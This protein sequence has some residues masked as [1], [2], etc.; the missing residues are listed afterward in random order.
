MPAR[1]QP[2][3]TV[4]ATSTMLIDLSEDLY[5]RTPTPPATVHAVIS[6]PV[7]AEMITVSV[8]IQP[9]PKAA[10]VAPI[11]TD[12]GNGAR[13]SYLMVD[14]AD[15]TWQELRDYVVKQ[16]SDRNIRYAAI[17]AERLA[18]IFKGFHA[19]WGDQ[20][21]AIARYAFEICEGYWKSA[22]ITP[23]R[24]SKNSDPY[25]ASLIA[26]RLLAA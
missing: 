19:R 16:L 14:T 9:E 26:P 12:Y 21:A 1:A 15:W 13:A 6:L 20:A 8:N 22:P 4:G 2:L 25:F 24:F 18:S 10:D 3:A 7:P 17:P 23:V 11:P 5:S